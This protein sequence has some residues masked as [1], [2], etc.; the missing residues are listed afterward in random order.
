[1][2]SRS[3]LLASLLLVACG[4]DPSG[5][6]TADDDLTGAQVKQLGVPR[7]ILDASFYDKPSPQDQSGLGVAVLP[8]L[9]IATGA[10]SQALPS[11]TTLDGKPLARMKG[12]RVTVGDDDHFGVLVDDGTG[13][14]ARIGTPPPFFPPDQMH[15]GLACRVLGTELDMYSSGPP[16]ALALDVT[17]LQMRAKDA[18]WHVIAKSTK[19]TGGE[20]SLLV[21]DGKLAG[22]SAGGGSQGTTFEFR[23]IDAALLAAVKK[24]GGS[25]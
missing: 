23:S 15:E 21:C 5:D 14:G 2:L 11:R 4:S 1:V 25:R 9:A 16:K 6:A 18:Y 17:I 12:K 10:T 22:V 8:G 20:M 7:A 24:A 13:E 19:S 3:L